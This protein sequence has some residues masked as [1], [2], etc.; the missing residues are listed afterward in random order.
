M[1]ETDSTE[2]QYFAAMSERLTWL[3][4]GQTVEWCRQD[5]DRNLTVKF[6]NG[7]VL[8]V[9]IP[10]S[11]QKALDISVVSSN[12]ADPSWEERADSDGGPPSPQRRSKS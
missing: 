1:P 12:D 3:L 2:G 4:S 5:G 7:P 8:Y 10:S 6:V 11:R 9:G